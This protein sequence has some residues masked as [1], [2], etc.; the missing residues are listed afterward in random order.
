[1]SSL[2]YVLKIASNYK[3]SYNY[4]TAHSYIVTHT[5][6]GRP[7]LGNGVVNRLR[8]QYRLGFLLGPCKVVI[9]EANSE[10]GISCRSTEQ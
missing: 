3:S 9:R 8:Q 6:I 7:L 2:Y 1:M 5:I 4:L 10:A